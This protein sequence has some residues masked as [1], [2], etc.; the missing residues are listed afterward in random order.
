MLLDWVR[1]VG[2]RFHLFSRAPRFHPREQAPRRRIVVR[3]LVRLESR[4]FF[5]YGAGSGAESTWR[6]RNRLECLVPLNRERISD[7]GARYLL[8]DWEWFVPLEDQEERSA[9]RQ[10]LRTGLGYRRR[11]NWR[12]EAIYIRTRSRNTIEDGFDTSDNIIN[13]RVKRLF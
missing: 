6:F 8:A 11:F 5:Y 1:T 10:R 12:F 7:E 9:N 4:N 2:A 3:D 13:V